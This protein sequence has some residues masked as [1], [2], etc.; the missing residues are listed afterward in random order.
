MIWCG[1]PVREPASLCYG[2][3]CGPD[4][5]EEVKK[6]CRKYLLYLIN[7]QSHGGFIWIGDPEKFIDKRAL[8]YRKKPLYTTFAECRKVRSFVASLVPFT[9]FESLICQGKL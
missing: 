6:Q 8:K 5:T 3:G 2:L 9:D 4:V 1:E 7:E